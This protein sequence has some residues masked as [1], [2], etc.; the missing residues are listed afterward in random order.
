M[1]SILLRFYAKRPYFRFCRWWR[2]FLKSFICFGD[3]LLNFVA[4]PR[5]LPFPPRRKTLLVVMK[6]AKMIERKIWMFMFLFDLCSD[7]VLFK[8]SLLHKWLPDVIFETSGNIAQ[9]F[10]RIL[11]S[12][13]TTRFLT[14]CTM[15]N[16]IFLMSNTLFVG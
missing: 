4:I 7:I 6:I 12:I 1:I 3:K 5:M 13:N 8:L 16:T 14:S 2:S 10:Y 11:S 15:D 9:N